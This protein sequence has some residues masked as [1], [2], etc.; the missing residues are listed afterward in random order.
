[1]RLWSLSHKTWLLRKS[2]AVIIRLLPSRRIFHDMYSHNEWCS[3][4]SV[5]GPGSEM[6]EVRSVVEQ[7]P[8]M[9]R[10]LSIRSLCDIPCGDFNWMKHVDLSGIDYLGGDIV[11]EVIRKNKQ[12]WENSNTRFEVLDITRSRLPPVALIMCRDCLVH[13]SFRKIRL[14]IK[15]MR[16]SQS[17][18]ALLTHFPR[19]ERNMDIPTGYW[20]PLNL[21]LVPFNWPQPVELIEETSSRS[22]GKTLGLWRVDDIPMQ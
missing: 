13:L 9:L 3:G 1:M 19:L 11:R 2:S 21:T 18:Y 14:A 16:K 6:E 10:R 5:S 15:N 20:R 17:R 12:Q 22:A 7:L 8:G 4:E